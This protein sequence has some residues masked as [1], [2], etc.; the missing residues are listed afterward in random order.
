MRVHIIF[1]LF[2]TW[3]GS[4]KSIGGIETY[5]SNLCSVITRMGHAASVYQVGNFTFEKEFD[6]VKVF[7]YP[8]ANQKNR[9]KYLLER[10]KEHFDY[11][12]DVV[13]FG[14]DVIAQPSPGMRSITIQHG[15]FWDIP[16]RECSNDLVY[17]AKFV[18][19]CIE[20]W[21]HVKSVS[22]SDRLVC[23]DYNFGNWY[24]A[25]TPFPKTKM[26]VIPNFTKI[27]DPIVKP[28]RNDPAQPVRIMFA[29]RF[30]DYRGTRIFLAAAKR[31]LEKYSSIEI[32]LAG[33]G[34][35]EE[36]LKR[37]LAG[38]PNVRF[39][40]Y[41]SHESLDIHADKDIAVVPTLASEGTSLSLLEAMSAQC[42]VVCTNVGGMTNIVIDGYN[43]LMISPDVDSLYEAMCK[44]ID[45]ANLRQELSDK[46]YETVQ[47]GFSLER[48]QDAWEGVI[49]SMEA[50]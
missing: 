41:E 1:D 24:R 21:S 49:R 25:V 16:R 26:T 43:G 10:C 47:K 31:L 4:H 19:Q 38:H 39:I 27:A 12:K 33:D 22:H 18:V 34:P 48:W 15:I 7:G 5:I 40:T 50:G 8:I 37:E 35:D 11:D 45:D 14:N 6:G 20:T 32:T 23:V 46:A 3:D 9:G 36:L 17:L 29:R 13:I 44:L 2:L 30:W 42:A 28:T